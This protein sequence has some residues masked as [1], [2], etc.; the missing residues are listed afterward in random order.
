MLVKEKSPRYQLTPNQREQLSEAL[1]TIDNKKI[2]DRIIVFL[3]ADKGYSNRAIN[4]VLGYSSIFAHWW[5][6][7]AN[8]DDLSSFRT[9]TNANHLSRLHKPYKLTP[10]NKKILLEIVKNPP[11]KYGVNKKRWTLQTLA[12]QFTQ[13]TGIKIS[14][15][16][17]HKLLIEK[18]IKLKG[19]IK[20]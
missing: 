4:K 1:L 3:L 10:E 20:C 14:P 11:T 9:R 5:L 19:P 13:E 16:H 7:R 6:R 8:P 12:N 17:T 15:T 2:E 18:N